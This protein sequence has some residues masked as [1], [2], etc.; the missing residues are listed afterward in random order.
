MKNRFY[1]LALALTLFFG[2][3]EKSSACGS[4]THDHAS[5]ESLVHEIEAK[6][7]L[8]VKTVQYRCGGSGIT[9]DFKPSILIAPLDS[10]YKKWNESFALGSIL[11]GPETEKQLKQ[12]LSLSPEKIEAIKM[13]QSLLVQDML[14]L[15]TTYGVDVSLWSRDFDATG[16]LLTVGTAVCEKNLYMSNY[17]Y[18]KIHT[19][20]ANIEGLLAAPEAPLYQSGDLYKAIINN[21][22]VMETLDKVT[23][24]NLESIKTLQAEGHT[25][26]CAND[27]FSWNSTRARFGLAPVQ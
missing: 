13:S 16:T 7:N 3:T 23:R 11:S 19:G 8:K 21:A 1:S 22:Q 4:D 25:S 5:T 12:L 14:F 9:F 20:I 24:G 26:R 15:E 2:L 17:Q 6:F 18:G 10:D 27:S